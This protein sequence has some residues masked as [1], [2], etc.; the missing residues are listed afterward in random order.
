MFPSAEAYEERTNALL[1]DVKRFKEIEAS[2][3]LARFHELSVF[4]LS[5]EF[6]E[7]K[8]QLN[9]L[10][11]KGSSEFQAEKRLHELT[12]DT[13]IKKYFSFKNS[14]NFATYLRL[15]D[16]KEIA[17]FLELK[18]MLAG[19]EFMVLKREF[20][21]KNTN[22]YKALIEYKSLR[23][24][25]H[26][27][28]HRKGKGEDL[29][30]TVILRYEELNK[31]ISS[32]GF[33]DFLTSY[34][35]SNTEYFGFEQ[36]FKR[37]NV[38]ADIRTYLKV[39]DSALLKSMKTIEAGSSLS[40]LAE[41]EKMVGSTD[42]QS[43]KKYLLSKNKFEQS[44]EFKLLLE[45]K[46]LEKDEDIRFYLKE[47]KDGRLT[48]YLSWSLTFEENFE[49]KK[50]NRDRWLTRYFWGDALLHKGYS[51]SGE[52]Q[53]FTDGNNL[54]IENSILEIETRKE[55]INGIVWDG[56]LGFFPREF[57]YTSGLISTGQ[58]FRQLYGRFEAKV[59][60]Q[61]HYPAFHAFWMVGDKMLPQVTIFKFGNKSNNFEHG[62]YHG[63]GLAKVA[64]QT[65]RLSLP[66]INGHFAVFTIDWTPEYILWKINGV[67]VRK[68]T[69]NVPTNPMYMILSSGLASDI[70]DGELPVKMEVDWVRAF[71]F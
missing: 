15:K 46:A 64:R 12:H 45:F 52:K 2:P 38:N 7:K 42:F 34:K 27:K 57:S 59:K 17:R 71:S 10:T 37:L 43:K 58:S 8:R 23:K 69:K 44:E 13:G 36:E 66:S 35:W 1:H 67:L 50:L 48:P 20:S 28:M 33:S 30:Q 55:K 25:P 21:V 54:R 26:V 40:E 4:V 68:E 31:T 6:A 60:L 16:S 61:P 70:N 11:Y 63:D 49:E 9:S 5:K 24:H 32:P 14:S 18:A 22:E 53:H 29:D 56:K 62:L 3:K 51:L 19:D 65:G 47:K 41:L 39:A